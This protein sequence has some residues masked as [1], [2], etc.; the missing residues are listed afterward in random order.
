[1]NA[2]DSFLFRSF[3]NVTT[4]RLSSLASATRIFAGVVSF[5]LQGVSIDIAESPRLKAMS[6][7]PEFPA[8]IATS[9]HPTVT[10]HLSLASQERIRRMNA[11]DSR[12]RQRANCFAHSRPP[13]HP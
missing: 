7:S 2:H 13:L 3:G 4:L 8:A 5:S 9:S 11:S 12:F 1:M 6:A 10:T